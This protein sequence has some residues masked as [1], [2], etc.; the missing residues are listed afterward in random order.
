[1]TDAPDPRT[2][3]DTPVEDALTDADLEAAGAAL[4]AAVPEIQSRDIAVAV[5][6]RQA[7]RRGVAAAALALALVLVA[8]SVVL[9]ND[10]PPSANLASNA[11]PDDARVERFLAT[12]DKQPIDPT[13]VK[14]IAS[15]KSFDSCDAL[16]GDLRKVG[17]QHVGSRGFGGTSYEQFRPV[18]A[19]VEDSTTSRGAMTNGAPT[20]EKTTLG[21]NVQVAGVDELDHVKAVGKYIYDLDGQGHFRVTDSDSLQVVG[22]VVINEM[23]ARHGGGGA[24][25]PEPFEGATSLLVAD[26]HAVVFG[27]RT[28]TS[29]PVKGDPSATQSQS[30]Y[31][32]VTFIDLTNPSKP[33]VTDRVDIEG[34]LVSARLVDG[35]IRM[36]TGA[37]MADLG[38]VMPTTPNSVAKA[39][40]QNRR[41]VAQST[42]DDWIPTWQRKGD[43]A[44][45]L[46]PCERV[47]VP[48]TFAG[49]A[50][51]SMVTFPLAST[52]FKPAGTSILAPST[53]LYGG[54]DRV[55]I[56]S[57]VWVDPIDQSRKKFPNW[58]TAIHEFTFTGTKAPRYEGSGI[59]DG[60]TIGQFSFGELGDAL[61]VITSKGTPWAHKSSAVNLTVLS[62]DKNGKLT[63][64]AKLDDLA[65]GKGAVSAVRFIDGRILVS[66]GF[67]GRRVQV[68]DVEDPAKPRRGGLI[69]LT[70]DVSYFHPI[71]NQRALLVGSRYDEIPGTYG[72]ESRPWVQAQLAD[73]SNADKPQLVGSWEK[74]WSSDEVG[75]DHH[76]FT[77]WP[78]R[79][80]AMW[81]I[82]AQ[83]NAPDP[84]NHAAILEV[85]ATVNEQ[86]FPTAKKPPETKPACPQVTV[87]DPTVRRQLGERGVLL[88]CGSSD[89]TTLEWPR[90]ICQYLPED[91]VISLVPGT[92]RNH[93]YFS[94]RPAPTPRVSRV[95]V[96]HGQLLLYTDQ[97]IER[98]DPTTFAST[99]VVYHPSSQ[100]FGYW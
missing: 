38:F 51:T 55:A 98:L 2:P 91:F 52:K 64:T 31:L 62:P 34:D 49:V 43:K 96:V 80:L 59:V 50:M 92:D 87:T 35:Q 27:S 100:G 16:I 57:E 74:P 10:S 42:V 65:P 3:D 25:M 72:P 22:Q 99:A 68:V 89:R 54:L 30:N 12:L 47:N 32:T 75:S 33:T 53:T 60:A 93:T 73:F 44:Q 4:R 21:T 6:V 15:V 28:V 45:P 85:A 88:D 23:P 13:Q 86:A 46:V 17:A 82:T 37:H 77:W 40:E 5:A 83:N 76:A 69:T 95:L 58:Q 9:R 8:T 61:A 29:A 26:K 84:A 71:D 67:S 18:A 1:M 90:Y 36:V 20:S 41:S 97:T 70:G 78:D 56:S 11:K 7:R 14:L 81:G 24:A 19:A 79:K 48:S 66:T 63:T 39:L 94:C